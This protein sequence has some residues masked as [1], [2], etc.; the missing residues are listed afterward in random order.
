MSDHDTIAAISTP[1]GEGGIGIIR[2]SG[3]D[4]FSITGRIFSF[5]AGGRL[6]AKK[7][8]GARSRLMLYGFITDPVT[9]NQLDEVLVAVMHAPNTYTREDMI[10]INCH[11]GAHTISRTM[12]LVL[13]EG[14]RLALP[15]EFT[16]RAFLG[17]RI[18]L[19][20][21]EAVLSLVRAKSDAAGRAALAQLKGGLGDRIK[22][23]T[24]RLTR[25]CA[26]LEASIDFP[27]E[28]IEPDE[29]SALTAGI[30]N[31]AESLRSLSNTYDEGKLV[32][33]G[34]R[35]AIL[36]RPNVGKSSLLNALLNRERAIVTDIPGTTRDVIAEHINL[37]GYAMRLMDTAGI[38][39][40]VDRPE[41]EGVKRSLSAMEDADLVLCVLDGSAGAGKEDLRVISLIKE[42][43]K[44][45]ILVINKKDLFAD[46][47]PWRSGELAESF[48]PPEGWP[49]VCVSAKTGGGLEELKECIA[50]IF[51]KG[52]PA[53]ADPGVLVTSLRHKTALDN[54]RMALGRALEAIGEGLPAEIVSL[55][56]SEALR[57]LGGI[58]GEVSNEDI[59]S[60]IF[61]EF[62]IGK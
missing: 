30:E 27:E 55:E 15:G 48:F 40:A 54:A 31:V 62:C 16:K 23:E 34:I 46:K 33:E 17:G 28:E 38:R 19:T 21:A 10:E 18:D 36:G 50:G 41:A 49:E 59:L 11:G 13:R 29:T 56:L 61:N 45:A 58:T 35:T 39:E 20:Q 7:L 9:G 6:K 44:R 14:A 24:G 1:P 5:S 43:G 3:P 37:G 25:I 53:E 47:K 57:E 52:G 51:R 12:E 42:Q 2:L 22:R 8:R 26:H 32:S 60:V 4:A